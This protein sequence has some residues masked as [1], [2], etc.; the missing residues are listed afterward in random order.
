MTEEGRLSIAHTSISD[1]SFL[2]F[3]SRL[4]IFLEEEEAEEK[5]GKPFFNNSI[6][7]FYGKFIT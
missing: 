6:L 2:F 7:M 4:D 1:S 5:K 3:P